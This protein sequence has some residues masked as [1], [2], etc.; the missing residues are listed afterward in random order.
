MGSGKH[1][2]VPSNVYFSGGRDRFCIP[3]SI[4]RNAII[5]TYSD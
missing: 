4:E 3:N 1:E 5:E 2:L